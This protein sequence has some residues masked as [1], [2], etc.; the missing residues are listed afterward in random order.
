MNTTQKRPFSDDYTHQYQNAK[1]GLNCPLLKVD[2]FIKGKIIQTKIALI[3]ATTPP[4]LS[5][6]ERKIA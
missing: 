4:N 2:V 3:I 6:I 5:G 1:R